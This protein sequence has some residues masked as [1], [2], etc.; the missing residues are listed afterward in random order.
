MIRDYHW[1]DLK[2]A[3]DFAAG[4]ARAALAYD[5]GEHRADLVA[6]IQIAERCAAGEAIDPTA[7]YVAARAA[8]YAARAARTPYNAVHA[9]HAAAYTDYS[10]AHVAA[11]A[12][13]AG[14]DQAEID[15]LWRC[16]RHRSR[17]GPG[18]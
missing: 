8:A 13:R 16:R 2:H 14:V 17:R 3:V 12:A 18:Q 9:A 1:R 11:H 10:V 7:A 15:A 5:S 6:A 4:C